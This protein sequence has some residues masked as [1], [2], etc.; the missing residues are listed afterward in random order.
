MIARVTFLFLICLFQPIFVLAQ[1]DSEKLLLDGI[2][3]FEQ[4]KFEQAR[5]MLEKAKKLDPENAEIFLNLGMT[6]YSLSEFELALEN[7]KKS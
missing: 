2:K 6:H 3:L 4:E 7:L 5:A 1:D